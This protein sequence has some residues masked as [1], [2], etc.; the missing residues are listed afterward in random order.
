[1]V[2]ANVNDRDALLQEARDLRARQRLPEALAM[3]ARLQAVYPLFSRLYQERGHCHVMLG[4]APAA[5][6]ALREAVRLNPTLPQSWDMLEQL[7]R[8]A[9]DPTQAAMAARHLAMLRQLPPEVVMANSLLA[10]GDFG[11]AEDILRDYLRKDGG[12]VGALRL[13]ARICTER[14]APDEAEALLQ[15]VLERAPD[16]HAARLD[17]AMA[18]LQQQKHLPARQEAERLL[19]HDPD[20]REYLKQY[21]AACVGLGDYEPVIDLYERLLAGQGQAGPE[22]ADLR[23]WRANA[24]KITGRQ[25]EAIA[26]YRASLTARPDNGVAWFSL[27][28]LKTYRFTGDEI[29]R[30]RAAEA[31]PGVQ[32][33]DRAYLNFALGKAMEDEGDYAASWQYYERGNAVRRVM[34]RWRPE[35]AD[36]CAA[37]LKQVLTA[38]FFAARAGWGVD[39]P[40]P[41]FILGLPRS[42]STLFEQILASHSRVEGTQELT[43]I[44][45]YAGELC[46]RDPDCG[47]PLRPEML[48]RLTSRDARAL[49]ERFLADTRTHRRL[50]RPFFIDKM[51]NNFWH[52]GLIHLILPRAAIIDVRRE[53]MACCFSNLK[54]LF[55]TTNQEF[56]YGVDHIAR[57]YRT[58]LDLMRHWDGVLPGRILRAPYEDVVEDL[59]G[60][61]RRMLAHCEL[62]F[63]SACLTFHETRRSIRTPSSEQVRQPIGREG[64]D[65][66]RH[67][68]PWLGALRD[69][70]GDALT[71]YGT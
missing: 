20:N 70:L 5:V 26:D 43:E 1:M 12:N 34:S 23:L 42:G 50:G 24:L 15:S 55:G 51:P 10:D 28:N 54:Q 65:Q 14:G 32:D 48:A 30:M 40:A 59:E 16:Y 9:G 31:R 2:S 46:G 7:Y 45:R 22:V 27:A 66:W 44:G 61:V 25:P 47:L 13:L 39:D 41:I 8:M 3:L 35:V 53:P 36:D 49:G 21:S 68:A 19:K 69:G 71:R 57:Y 29:T 58:Y 60:G 52:I 56:T 64:L 4:N 37:R 11:P 17:Y 6:D 62:P 33:M 63:E 18:L 38:E 67:Y